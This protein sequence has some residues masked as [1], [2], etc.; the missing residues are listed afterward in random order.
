[1][2]DIERTTAKNKLIISVLVAVV[3][4]DLQMV[5]LED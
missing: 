5:F 2:K 4:L 1:M 3:V